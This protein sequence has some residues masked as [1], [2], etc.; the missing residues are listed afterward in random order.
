MPLRLE[1]LTPDAQVTGLIGREAVRI[2]SSGIPDEP[3]TRLVLMAA[4]YTHRR[5]VDFSAALEWATSA[6]QSKGNSPR[7]YQ[8]TLVFLAPDEQNLEN[9][10]LA[11]ADRKAWTKVLDEKLL[12]NL[13]AN[14]EQQAHAKVE[15]A[16]R[17]IALRIPETWCHL[18]VPYQNEPGPHGANWDEKRLTGG[19]GSLA[20]RAAEKCVQEDLLSDQLGARVLRDKLN[21]FLWRDRPHVAVRELVDWCHKYLY[22]PRIASDQVILDALVNPSAALTGESTFYLADS[23]DEASGRYQGLRPQQASSSQLPSLNSLI[24]KEEVAK[25]QA[26]EPPPV[27]IPTTAGETT[28]GSS[29]LRPD[30]PQT[31]VSTTAGGIAPPAAIPLPARNTTFMASLKLDPMRAGLQMGDFL[32]EVLS[33]LQALP[34]AEV[35]LS[36]EVHVKAPDGIDDATARVVLENSRSLKVDNPQIY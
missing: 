35:N 7:Q 32:D 5:G 36:V 16:T 8:N 18:L 26:P 27:A 23:F 22:L 30:T 11:L 1:D 2:V 28:G 3:A 15:D 12:L 19:K 20:Q 4:Q 31:T 34:G 6:L 17:T 33:H 10:F 9:L 29:G 24:V 21:A 25:A 13:T 14:Q